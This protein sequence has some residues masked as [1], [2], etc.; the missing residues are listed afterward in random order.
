MLS[1]NLNMSEM[2]KPLF[3][4]NLLSLR[5]DSFVPQLSAEQLKL[6]A[7]WASAVRDPNF[8]TQNEKPHQGA[9]LIQMFAVLLGYAH[10][11]AN[12]EN[13]N[14]K[15][16]TASSETKGGKTPDGRLGFYSKN[17]DLTRV[18]IE[19]KPPA[20]SLDA[21]QASHGGMTPVEQAFSY[22]PKFDGCRWVIVSNF[23]TLR[24]YDS[25]RGEGYCH[26]WNI[27]DLAN[28]ESAREFLYCLEKD[29]LISRS[30]ES[31]ID[32]LGRASYAQ[33]E[34]ITKEFYKFYK[35][36]RS[37]LFDELV[38]DNPPQ[39]DTA[40]AEHEIRLLEKAQK[41]LDR[42]L[43]ICFSESRGL[44][45]PGLIRKAMEA[46]R[47]GFVKTTRWQQLAGLFDA[48]D[49][50]DV[51]Q[52]INGYNGGLFQHDSELSS[53]KV[54]D[55][56]LDK[57][58]RLSEYD[59][60][61][62]LNVNIL[63]HIFEQSVSD[64]EA[65]RGDIRGEEIDKKKSRRKKEGVFYTP[66]LITRFIVESTIGSWLLERFS[67]IKTRYPIEKVRGAKKRVA[68][69]I[70]M[71]EEYRRTLWNI[72][73]LD[74]AC[75][76]GAF[77]VAA[78]DYL[79]AEYTRVNNQLSQLRR[80]Q[81]SI[82]DWDKQI[83]QEN[84]Y[85]VDL[86]SES[87]E[88]T[89]LSL[90]LKTA[91]K[92]KPLNNLDDNIKCGN[93]IVPLIDCEGSHE[94]TYSDLPQGIRDRAFD[95]KAEF[96]Q[97]FDQGGFDCLIGNPPYI[98]AERL[99]SY[100]PYLKKTYKCFSS[101]ADFYI[102]FLEQGLGLLKHGGRLGYITSGTFARTSFAAPFR[103]WLPKVARFE[104][105]VNFG[106]NQP[107]EDAEMVYPTISILVKDTRPRTFQTLFM[108]DSVPN[109]I[110]AALE[111]ENVECDEQVFE[112]PEWMFQGP[113]VTGLCNRIM[114]LGCALKEV[115]ALK[116]YYG[117]KTGLNEAFII[118][119]RTRANLIQQDKGSSAI[120]RELLGGD[121]LRPWYH[122]EQG[123]WLVFIPNGTSA[124]MCGSDQESV[125]RGWLE[126]TY[127]AIARHLAQFKDKGRDRSD[128]GQFW[129][130]LRP[131]DYYNE[132]ASPK[133][134]WPDI[135]KLPRFSWDTTG[136]IINNTGYILTT[137]SHWILSI[138]Q[139][140]LIW[141]C[142]SQIS[143]PLRLRASLWQYRCIR[144]FIERLPI[145]VPDE[146]ER[147]TLAALAMRA[148]SIAN[149]RYAHHQ[150]VRHRIQTDLGDG[151]TGLNQKLE[152]WW[153]TDFPSFRK[154]VGTALGKDIPLKERVEW[155]Q[156][157]VDW[158][159][160][161]D[162]LTRELVNI[163]EEINSRVFDLYDLSD[164]DIH[165]LEDHCRKD[166]IYYSYGE[167]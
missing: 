112:K 44:L 90:W 88:I 144:Q 25:A 74:P 61:T 150:S 37:S 3:N 66:D 163:E 71:W 117:I 12:P 59:F 102:Y 68:A 131:C 127:P 27:A 167:P 141:F 72:K 151:K 146:N 142:I 154:E 152:K 128:Q 100:K 13:Y 155:E 122:R 11:T 92:N 103:A 62:D 16:E 164:T 110:A 58:V 28:Q 160:N 26:Q 32:E 5:V 8:K 73:V 21:K 63:G 111:T 77:L 84:I 130:E 67:E 114:S 7:D 137:D 91:R 97:V 85:G 108:R 34:Q 86:N 55:Q 106:E 65:L 89:K 140:R 18:V 115:A 136:C 52:R 46:A 17:D 143:T 153:M 105:V 23:V 124:E 29:H 64:L 20:V 148:T 94:A 109:S 119:H 123:R 158:R 19:L 4:R 107:F 96:Q 31:I 15:A 42:V 9:F 157:L 132:F 60:L 54:S 118:D 1:R 80:G 6:L 70:N 135:S 161:H 22:V 93:S 113:H 156:A 133:I 134:L 50:G 79:L 24:L 98:R 121:D 82:F 39:P 165:L 95:W 76:S 159:Q 125:A 81:T 101:S 138:L 10:Y 166:M 57:F 45:P 14:L 147:E 139:S 33:E 40:K 75:G 41:I 2:F 69:E 162:N 126:S 56:F 53:L 129:W 30:A 145:I 83:L 116:I 120:L 51:E 87:V 47:S 36:L 38:R 149:E 78:F 99:S 49:T 104:K 43:F 48:I 35:G